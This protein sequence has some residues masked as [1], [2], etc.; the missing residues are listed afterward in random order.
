MTGYPK[1]E[2]LGRNCRSLQAP[3]SGKGASS[4]KPGSGADKDAV[5]KLRHAIDAR[6]EIQLELVNYKNGQRFKNI[7]NVIPLELDVPGNHYAVGFQ[8]EVD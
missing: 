6:K 4:S 5:R 2:V 7:L 1:A 3:P 8:V